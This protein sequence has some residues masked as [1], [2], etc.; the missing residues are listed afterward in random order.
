[1]CVW[2][3]RPRFLQTHTQEGLLQNRIDQCITA[4]HLACSLQWL[5]AVHDAHFQFRRGAQQTLSPHVHVCVLYLLDLQKQGPNQLM[6]TAIRPGFGLCSFALE[7]ALRVTATHKQSLDG[8]AHGCV[9]GLR[10]GTAG[11][12]IQF[13]QTSMRLSNFGACNYIQACI[14]VQ[15]HAYDWV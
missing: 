3:W 13:G 10:N 5:R 11:H 9:H 7:L 14:H 6:Q 8:S 15:Q 1:M 4:M 2:F 12:K